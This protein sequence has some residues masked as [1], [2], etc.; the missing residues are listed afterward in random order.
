MSQIVAHT[1]AMDTPQTNNSLTCNAWCAAP[2]WFSM[3]LASGNDAPMPM[4]PLLGLPASVQPVMAPPLKEGCNSTL[5]VAPRDAGGCRHPHTDPRLLCVLQYASSCDFV[6]C[7]THSWAHNV[8]RL[9]G[10]PQWRRQRWPPSDCSNMR[11]AYPQEQSTMQE[12][13]PLCRAG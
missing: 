10:D 3:F 9:A 4:H 6:R 5:Q 13:W 8:R 7:V 2:S 12:P 11:A 1:H